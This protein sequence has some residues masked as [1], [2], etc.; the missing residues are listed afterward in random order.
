MWSQQRSK[1]LKLTNKI[2]ILVLYGRRLDLVSSVRQPRMQSYQPLD[3]ILLLLAVHD[4]IRFV[5]ILLQTSYIIDITSIIMCSRLLPILEAYF[6][7]KR[8]INNQSMWSNYFSSI[9][10]NL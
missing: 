7:D 9:A 8:H 2:L 5:C 3:G 10:R 1:G 4:E 6:I